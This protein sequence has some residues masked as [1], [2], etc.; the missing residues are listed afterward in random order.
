MGSIAI[1]GAGNI[2]LGYSVSSGKIFPSI[3][4]AT[5]KA[6][7]PLGTLRDEAVLINGRGAQ[8]GSNRWGD[9]SAMAIDPA[10][11]CSFWYTNEF[12]R[13]SSATKW[14]TEI[15]VFSVPGC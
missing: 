11:D 15:G 5:R 13:T 3:R 8:T 12:Y 14:T 2:A 9:Y 7:D 4:F 10:D 6:G 1:D